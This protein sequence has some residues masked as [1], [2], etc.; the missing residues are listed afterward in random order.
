MEQEV[1]QLEAEKD[2][3]IH[4]VDYLAQQ[5][6]ELESVVVGLEKS[7]GLE[8]WTEMTPISLPDP[9]MSTQADMQR[10]AM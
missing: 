2:R 5:Q 4:T 8:D 10:Q 9:T 6:G 3:Y 1:R 7:L